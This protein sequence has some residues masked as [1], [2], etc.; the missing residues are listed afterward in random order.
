M[1]GRPSVCQLWSVCLSAMID[2]KEVSL[3]E[4]GKL[5][6]EEFSYNY[7]LPF[8]CSVCWESIIA[9]IAT[10]IP[11]F[12]LLWASEAVRLER[13]IRRVEHKR[14]IDVG[15]EPARRIPGPSAFQF[16]NVACKATSKISRN[17]TSGE[18]G[19]VCNQQS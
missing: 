12:A 1:C 19:E 4:S 5:R 13:N 11:F 15:V 2:S 3:L 8:R 18:T 14:G 16:G 7:T 17:N 10:A 6:G 9:E